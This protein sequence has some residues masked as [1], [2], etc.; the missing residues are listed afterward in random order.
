[1]KTGIRF[2]SVWLLLVFISKL[3]PSDSWIHLHSH[4]HTIHQEENSHKLIL[5]SEHHHCEDPLFFLSPFVPVAFLAVLVKT[6]LVSKKISIYKQKYFSKIIRF[7][8]LRGPPF[9]EF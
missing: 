4:S 2:I 7:H 1:M 5:D 9:F 6:E 8:N 3:I